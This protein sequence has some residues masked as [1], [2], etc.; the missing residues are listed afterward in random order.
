MEANYMKKFTFIFTVLLISIQAFAQKGVVSGIILDE[1]TRQPLEYVTVVQAGTSNAVNSN[2]DGTFIL[3]IPANQSVSIIFSLVNYE[4]DTVK[5]RLAKGEN[6]RID[7]ALKGREA[8]TI[9][10][11]DKR[12]EK[13][14][15]TG[16]TA[17]VQSLKLIPTISLNFESA[18]SIFGLGVNSGTGGE[19]SSQYSVRG[20]SYDENLIYV[21]DF[22]I[23]RPFLIRSGEQEGLTF[24]NIDMIRDLTFSSGGFEAKY[25]DK[26][27]SVL[28]INYKRPDS[29][30][31]SVG[32]SFLGASAHIEGAKFTDARNKSRNAFRYLIG[33]RYKTTQYLLGSLDLK[34]EYR[35]NFTDFQGSFTYD[36]NKRWQLSL[37]GNYAGS[38]YRFTPETLSSTL[39]LINFALQFNVAFEGQEIDEF[40]TYMSGITLTN[41]NE[42]KNYFLKLLAS[43]YG[44]QESER[45]DIIGYYRLGVLETDLGSSEFGEVVSILGT[46]TEHNYARNYLNSMVTNVAHKGGWQWRERRSGEKTQFLQWGVKYQHETID[47][48]LNEWTRIDSAGYSLRYDTTQVL[49]DKVIKT[50]INLASNRFSGFVQNSWSVSDSLREINLTVGVRAQYWDL[51][52]E[53]ILMPRLSLEYKPLTWEKE[54]SFKFATGLYHQPPFYREL[55]NQEGVINRDVVS[56]KSLHLVTGMTYDFDWDGRPFRLLGEVYYKRLWDIV[57][58][59]VDNVRIRYYGD[60]LATGYVTGL[61]LRL[62]GEFVKDTESWI[63]LSFMRARESFTGVE[64]LLRTAENP[65]TILVVKD[66]PRPTD[67]LMNLS[68]FFQD[69]FPGKP[70]FKVHTMLTVGSGLPFGLPEDNIDYRNI[71]RFKGYQRVDIGFSALLWDKKK[72]FE[73]PNHFLSFADNVWMSLEIFNLLKI[74]NSASNTWVKTIFLQQYAVPNYLTSRRINLRFKFDF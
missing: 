34:G 40:N 32:F 28:N 27:S 21:N 31:V 72:R 14:E 16:T 47:D 15:G 60:N 12:L 48:Q 26:L 29:L 4:Q 52:Q 20:G 30:K 51:N 63:N 1:D 13:S 59:D 22:E 66:V 61:D 38:K 18:L 6:R 54:V 42:E 73:K 2:P 71:Y 3:K 55:R 23:Y 58:Y 8:Q 39:G 57:P 67:R 19:L 49:L 44:S 37:I 69:Y 53:T 41:I 50:D 74:S 36:F 62:N 9:V 11:E 33:A 64:H 45:F 17:D 7:V 25:G 10:I 46:G 65:D 35:P 43:T 70:Q 5:V 68:M 24:P 56:Q